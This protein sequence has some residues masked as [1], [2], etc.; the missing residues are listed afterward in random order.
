[1]WI[2]ERVG[3]FFRAFMES[4]PFLSEN[5][6]NWKQ[7]MHEP[8]PKPP[9]RDL[10]NKVS[11]TA[12]QAWA[13]MCVRKTPGRTARELG[14]LHIPDNLRKIGKLLPGLTKL[15]LIEKG[16]QREDQ[17][18]GFLAFTHYPV[19]RGFTA[20]T[21]VTEIEPAMFNNCTCGHND[22]CSRC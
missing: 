7:E 4:D 8:W 9:K 13:L 16:E 5:V 10:D 2:W 15:G 1:V 12:D 18:T 21:Q 19:S 14:V 20:R 22:A 17:Y 6:Q 3:N 11:L